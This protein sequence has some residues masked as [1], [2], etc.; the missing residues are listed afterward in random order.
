MRV[1]V[2]RTM[3]T[4]DLNGRKQPRREKNLGQPPI[5]LLVV[6]VEIGRGVGEGV[7][8]VEA[9][10]AIRSMLG[11]ADGEDGEEIMEAAEAVEVGEVVDTTVV[12]GDRLLPIMFSVKEMDEHLSK[13]QS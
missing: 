8:R 10:K 9:N 5:H 6:E 11:F 2:D 3:P 7:S 13:F 4:P 1:L 12:I